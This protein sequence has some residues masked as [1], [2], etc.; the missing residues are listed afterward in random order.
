M[1]S[2]HDQRPVEPSNYSHVDISKDDNGEALGDALRT[3]LHL[4]PEKPESTPPPPGDAAEVI[5]PHDLPPDYV[6]RIVAEAKRMYDLGFW[7][8]PIRARGERYPQNG[9]IATAK[10]KEPFRMAW[11]TERW[12]WDDVEKEIRA[13]PGRGFGI[14]MGPGRAPGGRWL[15]DGEGDSPEAE[16]SYLKL[17]GEE[18]VNTMGWFSRRGKHRL[19]TV[20]G[21]RFLALLAD[22]GGAGKKG[23]PGVFHHPMFPGLELR[24]SGTNQQ[25]KIKQV[26]SVAAPC[27]GED[28]EPRIWLPCQDLAE[29][30]DRAYVTLEDIA[31]HL[32]MRVVDDDQH[33]ESNGKADPS[34]WSDVVVREKDSTG[35]TPQHAWF[36]DALA[37][38]AA[39]V[40]ST[41]K[42]GRRNRLR[43]A[44]YTLGGQLH[45]GYLDEYQ[46]VRALTEAGAKSGL[47]P[48][49][50]KETVDDGLTAG[51]AKPLAWPDRLDRPGEERSS[52]TSSERPKPPPLDLGMID[53]RAMFGPVAPPRWFVNRVIVADQPTIFG[54]PLKTLKTSILL[55]LLISLGS[56]TKFLGHFTVPQPVRV[57][58]ISGETGRYVLRANALEMARTRGIDIEQNENVFFGFTV[59]NLADDEHLIVVEKMLR[60]H[61]LEVLIL[62]P[63]YL[64]L[65]GE[66]IDPKSMFSMGPALS[67]FGKLCLDAGCLPIMAHHFTKSRLEPYA[68]PELNE[69]AY[70]G[71]SQWMRQWCLVTRRSPYK[72]DGRHEFHWRHGGS[73]GHSGERSLDIE[74]GIVD[75]NFNGRK[76]VVSVRSTSELIADQEQDRQARIVERETRKTAD[77][78]AADEHKAREDMAT[79][80]KIFQKEPDRRLTIT[81]LRKAAKWDSIRA[82]HVLYRLLQ[83]KFIRPC[84]MTVA[85]GGGVRPCEG[86]E[87]N[88]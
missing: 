88:E 62:D 15:M 35:T 33:H 38:E 71:V 50:V 23:E 37:D 44:A 20:D 47:D 32:A 80:L 58:M 2:P 69:L 70:G 22:S 87:L 4:P 75:E 45:H 51:K 40:A 34:L 63:F 79:A 57:G 10:G 52:S 64:S 54:G 53:A 60:Q 85:C 81:G 59:P 16:T 67:K 12:A 86:Y 14:V 6:E 56:G 82:G 66:D 19:L 5:L 7:V 13:I 55:D 30:P 83:D 21:E 77:K 84:P 46:V 8:I 39:A 18:P 25:G 24:I 78:N 43:D 1:S 9:T 17:V 3:A 28:G 27:L 42:G 48:G 11:G 36:R 73:F 68:P 61:K 72:D 31:E 41:P 76:W 74:T 65:H 26:Q 49:R 29:L